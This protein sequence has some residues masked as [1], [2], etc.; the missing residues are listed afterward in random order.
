M[1]PSLSCPL[2]VIS[3]FVKMGGKRILCFGGG[4][5]MSRNVTILVIILVILL[6]AGYLLWLRG[7]FQ[8]SLIQST[9]TPTVEVTATPIPTTTTASPSA[10]ATPSATPRSA[11]TSGRT[12]R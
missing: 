3:C 9:L 11:V 7:R 8:A 6:I 5:S 10:A 12:V 1:N 2:V 4:E